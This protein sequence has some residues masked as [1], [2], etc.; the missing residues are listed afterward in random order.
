[1]KSKFDLWLE[2][3]NNK[4]NKIWDSKFGYKPYDPLVY[5]R[6]GKYIKIFDGNSIWAFVSMVDGVN[7]G[8]RI[9]KGDLLKPAGFSSPAKHSRGNIFDGTDKWEYYGPAYLS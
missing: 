6:G 9:K 8:V 3:V 5:T 7:K 4:R 2:D 1:M